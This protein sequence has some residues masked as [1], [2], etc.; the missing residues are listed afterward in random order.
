MSVTSAPLE[1]SSRAR[2]SPTFPAPAMRTYIPAASYPS[3]A[4]STMSIAVWVG[5]TISRPC[6]AYQVARPGSSTRA[7]TLGT[8]KH[9]WAIWAMTRLVLSPLVDAMKTSASSMPA[10]SRASTS[11]AVPTVKRPPRS[12]QEPSIGSSSRSCD[13]GSSSR[14]DTSQSRA[15]ARLATAEPTRPAPTMR[16]NTGRRVP[17]GDPSGGGCGR[18]GVVGRGGEDH[19]ARR[20]P[21]HVLRHVAHVVVQGARAAQPPTPADARR[22]LGGQHDGL[23]PAPARLVDDGLPGAPGPHRRGGDLDALVLLPDGLGPG[24]RLPGP[25][26][27]AVGQPGLQRQGHRH[28]E[29]PQGLDHRAVG[30][31]VVVVLV[32]GQPPGGLD[33]VHVEVRAEDGHEDRAELRFHGL[34][35]HPQ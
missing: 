5:E 16:T 14:T 9:R 12:S 21:E 25:L 19:P 18:L 20:L 10:S 2:L 7:T 31:Q 28:L 29:H 17:P 15:M 4:D 1:M 34:G 6:S 27:L 26:E 24:Q 13:S 35:G 33:D 22:R 30:L 8:S 3:A 11:S 32:A 23:H